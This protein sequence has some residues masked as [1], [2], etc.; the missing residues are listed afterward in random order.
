LLVA[1]EASAQVEALFRDAEEVAVWWATE[2]EA[3]SALSRLEREPS[4]RSQSPPPGSF[5]DPSNSSFAL[6]SASSQDCC[7][8][9]SASFSQVRPVRWSVTVPS[10]LSVNRGFGQV[11][12]SWRC[13]S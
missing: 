7:P 2:V 8:K 13:P 1:E 4:I 11:T 5:A 12:P 9:Q 3:A 10:A 6:D